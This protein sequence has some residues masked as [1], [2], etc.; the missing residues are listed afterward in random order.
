VLSGNHYELNGASG[1]IA[2]TGNEIAFFDGPCSGV[3]RY[4]WSAQASMIHFTGLIA[5]PC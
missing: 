3:G 4:Q 5:D 1:S 2:V